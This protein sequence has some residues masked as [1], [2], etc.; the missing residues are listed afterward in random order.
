LVSR[1]PGRLA[2]ANGRLAD[3]RIIAEELA[4]S[5][6]GGF[7]FSLSAWSPFAVDAVSFGA[8]SALVL[9]GG[10]IISGVVTFGVGLTGNP[11]VAGAL[12]PSP[13]CVSSPSMSSW[14]H[15]VS[16]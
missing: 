10:S 7:L 12:L 14:S 11:W 16:G 5:P 15:C 6:S 4:G 13:G 8:S 9:T 2:R 1:D 3:T